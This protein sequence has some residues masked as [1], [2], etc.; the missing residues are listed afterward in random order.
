MALKVSDLAGKTG[1]TPDTIRYYERL[2]LL[3][4]AE[5][6]AAGYRQFEEPAARRIRFIKDGQSLGLKLSEIRDLLKV[7]DDGACPCGHTKD[8][9]KARLEQVN[10]EIQT[11]VALRAE[12]EE[13]SKLDCYP[14]TGESNWPCEISFP[15][16]GGEPMTPCDCPDCC[17]DTGDCTCDCC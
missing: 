10:R 16:K 4:P 1:V 7:Q 11:L 14:A 13:L 9:L 8:L 15:K 12:L 17:G 5:R 3:R 6:T 2:G